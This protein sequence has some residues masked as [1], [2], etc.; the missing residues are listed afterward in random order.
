MA[1]AVLDI[2][3]RVQRDEQDVRALGIEPQAPGEPSGAVW[4]DT[5]RW[6]TRLWSSIGRW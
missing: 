5:T 6:V 4:T 2:A 1:A 3:E